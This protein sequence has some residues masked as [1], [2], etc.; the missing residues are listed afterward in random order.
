MTTN[1]NSGGDKRRIAYT[2]KQFGRSAPKNSV[3]PLNSSAPNLYLD[4]LSTEATEAQIVSFFAAF[5][6]FG[7]PMLFVAIVA[8]VW[9]TWLI[10]LTIAPNATANYLMNTGQFDNGE[11]WLIVDPEP[12]L[13][14]C[15]VCGL[16]AVV[17]GYIFIISRMTFRRQVYVNRLLH[18]S[19]SWIQ[20][21]WSRSSIMKAAER[22]HVL[23]LWTELTGFH[24]RYRKL[25]VRMHVCTADLYWH[26]YLKVVVLF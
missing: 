15:S 6:A 5:G 7:I 25:W 14:V 22:S 26:F 13:I 1:V 24:G 4:E 17:L 23:T 11:F 10:I 9:T 16:S 20:Q 21:L 18:K 19:E 3:V 12:V 8:V 2:K